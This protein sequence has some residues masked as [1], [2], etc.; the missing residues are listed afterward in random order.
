MTSF[1]ASFAISSPAGELIGSEAAPTSG[2]NLAAATKIESSNSSS[3]DASVSV[4]YCG[5]NNGRG[6]QFK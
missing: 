6:W 3:L 2:E 1:V 5:E 4:K